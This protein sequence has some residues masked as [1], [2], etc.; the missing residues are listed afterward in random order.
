MLLPVHPL[1]STQTQN[2]SYPLS[3]VSYAP[4]RSA[5]TPPSIPWQVSPK[6][7]DTRR[8]RRLNEIGFVWRKHEGA[9]WDDKYRAF[10]QHVMRFGRS[11][12]VGDE[13]HAAGLAKWISEQR[14][15]CHRNLISPER[16]KMLALAGF[17]FRRQGWVGLPRTRLESGFTPFGGSPGCVDFAEGGFAQAMT[18]AESCQAMNAV[19]V[20]S[21]PIAGVVQA[22]RG[23]GDA[24]M[25]DAGALD[26]VGMGGLATAVE[27]DDDLDSSF[28]SGSEDME[29]ETWDIPWEGAFMLDGSKK[30]RQRHLKKPTQ[31]GNAEAA[32]GS[33]ISISA[34]LSCSPVSFRRKF[35][36]LLLYMTLHGHCNVPQKNPDNPKLGTWVMNQRSIY[37]KNLMRKDREAVLNKMGFSWNGMGPSWD[38]RLCELLLY[39]QNEGHSEVPEYWS[40]NPNLAH[41]VQQ[42]RQRFRKKNIAPEKVSLLE[43]SGFKWRLNA[44]GSERSSFDARLQ[45]LVEFRNKHGHLRVP[46]AGTPEHPKLGRWVWWLRISR[47]RGML[48][49]DRVKILDKM[50]FV[51]E[52]HHHEW[53]LRYVSMVKHRMQHG[54]VNVWNTSDLDQHL[55]WWALNQ[56]QEKTR[57]SL[58]VLREQ[59]MTSLGFEWWSEARKNKQQEQNKQSKNQQTHQQKNQ[60]SKQPQTFAQPCN[61]SQ[62]NLSR[63]HDTARLTMSRT[64]SDTEMSLD[65]TPLTNSGNN[66]D[67]ESHGVLLMT[68][69][70]RSLKPE[71][72]SNWI[73][74]FMELVLYRTR[75]GCVDIPV[76]ARITNC[77]GTM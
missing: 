66:L 10:V 21:L 16:T 34:I 26:G 37:D 69:R 20:M 49:E 47:R 17:D 68:K 77:N 75:H 11:W 44:H 13:P 4:P 70:R 61:H 5:W 36:D 1:C 62:S 22:I 53:D 54:H 55:V 12:V 58:P 29:G 64:M 74:A 30:E 25:M 71:G 2:L 56:R 3:I 67:L 59:L 46:Q 14:H 19:T 27:D 42:Q 52:A 65:S 18:A 8:I 57:G 38:E 31:Q 73:V 39:R 33:D 6:S 63:P 7:C 60:Q 72:R 43:R 24:M 9:L 50:K 15:K 76:S 40:G 28:K 35:N 45:Q 32:D 51:W 23:G 41:W 48:S